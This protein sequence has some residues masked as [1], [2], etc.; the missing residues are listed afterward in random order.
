MYHI[1]FI[2]FPIEGNFHLFYNFLPAANM[3][4][5]NIVEQVSFRQMS[6]I[7][8]SASYY[9]FILCEDLLDWFPEWLHQLAFSTT[10][11]NGFSFSV[12]SPVFVFSC[13][14]VLCHFNWSEISKEV[15]PFEMIILSTK[16]INQQKKSRTNS[17][18]HSHKWLVKVSYYRNNIDCQYGPWF[19]S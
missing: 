6:N 16:P 1:F 7:D 15:N 9:R 5:V 2:H 8:I 19:A 12:S 18:K 17:I 13:F 10:V 11:N 4:P 3:P 14:V